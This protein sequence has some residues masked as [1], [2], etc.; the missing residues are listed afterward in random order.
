MKNVDRLCR[1]ISIA[2]HYI[3]TVFKMSF[4]WRNKMTIKSE[5]MIGKTFGDWYVIKEDG[6]LYNRKAYLCKCSCGQLKRINGNELRRG[7]TKKCIK[8]R[9]KNNTIF[10]NGYK[11]SEHPLYRI[12][13]SILDRCYNK[14]NKKYKDYGGRGIKLCKRWEE[15]FLNFVNDLGEK[16][17]N[18]RYSIDRVD[19][20]GDYCPGNCRWATDVQQANN[21]RE[22]ISSY[23]TYHRHKKGYQVV[24]K[25]KFV[26]SY[27]TKEEAINKRD[28]YI[29]KN[30]IKVRLKNV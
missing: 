21:R 22:R 16:P 5:E 9:A 13:N 12:Y 28:E 25:G 24:I 6:L 17:Q 27:K 29:N 26:G 4:I 2:T 18:A 7:K 30:K 20:N 10:I 14:N 8:C 19:N 1:L 23:I 15:S 3:S 11:K